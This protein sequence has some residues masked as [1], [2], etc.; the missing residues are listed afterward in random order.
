VHV[1]PA[2]QAAE[3]LALRRGIGLQPGGAC[4]LLLPIAWLLI[5]GEHAAADAGPAGKL[6]DV[7]DA[8]L[9]QHHI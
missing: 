8:W 6:S 4:R 5:A 9:P 3:C 1:H 2:R 7:L